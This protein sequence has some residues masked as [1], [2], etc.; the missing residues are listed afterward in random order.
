MVQSWLALAA[1]LIMYVVAELTYHI[2]NSDVSRHP[3]H[4]PN[5]MFF[6]QGMDVPEAIVHIKAD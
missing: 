1:V 5:N 2:L 4:I 6:S 3:M